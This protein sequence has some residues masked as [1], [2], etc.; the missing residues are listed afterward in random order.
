MRALRE[1]RAAVEQVLADLG[2]AEGTGWLALITTDGDLVETTDAPSRDAINHLLDLPAA[3]QPVRLPAPILLRLGMFV[4][5]PTGLP[6]P[7]P[8]PNPVAAAVHAATAASGVLAPA[9][10]GPM[11]VTGWRDDV[12]FQPQRPPRPHTRDTLRHFH[13]QVRAV[14]NGE[15]SSLSRELEA[16]LRTFITKAYR[17]SGQRLP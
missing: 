15:P 10:Y 16:H 14:I 5:P 6:G 8:I 12:K 11:V 1:G 17:T 7:A 13:Q 4:Q 2:L 3:A 9:V